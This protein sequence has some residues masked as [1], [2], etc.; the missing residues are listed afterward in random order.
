MK[1]T[2]VKY[3]KQYFVDP[4]IQHWI[5]ARDNNG[6]FADFQGALFLNELD[7]CD[8]LSQKLKKI[9]QQENIIKHAEQEK[10][11]KKE[12]EEEQKKEQIAIKETENVLINGGT[13]KD[14]S[15]IVKIADKYGI[16]IP[17]RTRGWILNTLA[18]CNISTDGSVSCRYWK[19]SKGQQEVRKYMIFY[20]IL[21][22]F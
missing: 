20:S 21:E 2:Q 3:L 17:I 22:T 9:R 4:C 5:D 10:Q 12:A 13:I 8:E 7:K 16:N 15:L 1:K 6:K 19:R 18:E 11:R 14:G